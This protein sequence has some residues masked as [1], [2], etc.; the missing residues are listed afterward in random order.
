ML[1]ERPAKHIRRHAI[2]PDILKFN[3]HAC[4]IQR[5][6]RGAAT[7]A[8]FQAIEFQALEFLAIKLLHHRR[9]P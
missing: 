9:H 5:L 4:H 7:V 3:L 8:V 1:V 2:I 6:Q